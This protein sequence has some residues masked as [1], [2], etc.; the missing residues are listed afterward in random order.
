[1]KYFVVLGISLLLL[2]GCA[3]NSQQGQGVGSI[4][5][6]IVGGVVGHQFGSGSGKTIATAV[7]AVAGGLIGSE[8]GRVYDRLNR[9][10]QSI[11]TE[12]VSNTI[13]TSQI[14]EGNQWYNPQTGHSGRVI[15][16]EQEGYCREY[17]QIIVIGGREYDGY[18]TACRQ[19]DGSWKIQ[20]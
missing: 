12:T 15:I 6:A 1:M 5:G 14:G 10:E 11:H 2:F 16:T 18:G 3:P 13:Q 4:A 17:Q 7:G 8:L 9:E 20:N 19:P